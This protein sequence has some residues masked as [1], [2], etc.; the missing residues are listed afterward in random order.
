MPVPVKL[1]LR[2]STS[3]EFPIPVPSR[4][5]VQSISPSSRSTTFRRTQ[6]LVKT[7]NKTLEDEDIYA[8]S[9]LSGYLFIFTAY[10]VTFVSAFKARGD[11]Q[12]ENGTR[13]LGPGVEELALIPWKVSCTFYGSL[14]FMIGMIIIVAAHFDGF[15]LPRLWRHLFKVGVYCST[16]STGLGGFA[17]LNYNVYFSS[18][19]GLAASVHTFDTWL[20]DS[21]KA[22]SI[23]ER[24]VHCGQYASRKDIYDNTSLHIS[25]RRVLFIRFVNER[26]FGFASSS[27]A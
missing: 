9:R 7:R 19:A 21:A 10:C 11:E 8:S 1:T 3:A 12:K 15:L 26:V 6:N 17:G 25:L 13:S 2:E 27:L 16:S 22:S 18:W 4:W 5:F 23:S 20:K 24:Y 14:A